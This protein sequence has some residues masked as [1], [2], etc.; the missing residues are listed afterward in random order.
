MSHVDTNKEIA[1]ENVTKKNKTVRLREPTTSNRTCM[2][3]WRSG[4]LILEVLSQSANQLTDSTELQPDQ[5]TSA[6][7]AAAVVV[8]A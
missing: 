6:A 5:L 1:P 2:L 4:S 7:A 8:I 3:T